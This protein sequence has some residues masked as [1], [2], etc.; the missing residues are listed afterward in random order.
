MEK[1]IKYELQEKYIEGYWDGRLDASKELAT[2]LKK[3]YFERA[4]AE[5]WIEAACFDL[6]VA[7]ATG[8]KYP[9][10]VTSENPRP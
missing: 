7:I 2:E 4:N 3:A 10:E 8:F 6:A 9:L 1:T 5:S